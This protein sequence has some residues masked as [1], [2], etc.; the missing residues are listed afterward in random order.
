MDFKEEMA[1][2]AEVAATTKK[3]EKNGKSSGKVA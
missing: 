1:A 2:K 3:S